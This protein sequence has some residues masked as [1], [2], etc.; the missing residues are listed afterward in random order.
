MRSRYAETVSLYTESGSRKYLNA[1]ERERL[2]SAAASL[3]APQQLFVLTL[4]WTGARVSEVLALAPPAFQ[5]EAAVVSIRT[6]KRRRHHVR[7][8]PIPPALMA[9]LDRQFGLRKIQCDAGSADERLWPWSRTTAWR[10][11]KRVMAVAEISGAC[12]CPKGMRHAFGVATLGVVPLNIRQKWLGHA[13][14]ETTDIYSA[15]CG[16]EEMSFAR[17]F[18]QRDSLGK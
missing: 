1:A 13:R 18:W 4:T 5:I 14:P 11:V 6:L 15:V 12:A 7:E 8:V 3:P 16:P 2:L 10:R 17:Q 9:D